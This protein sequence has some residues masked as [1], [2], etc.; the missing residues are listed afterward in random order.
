L[1]NGQKAVALAQ[2]ARQLAGQDQPNILDTLAAA[3]AEAGR[4]GEAVET[5]QRALTLPAA[6]NNQLLADTLQKRL[7]LYQKNLPYHEGP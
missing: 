1:R 7:Q 3:Y 4:F 6:R 2:H 5:L